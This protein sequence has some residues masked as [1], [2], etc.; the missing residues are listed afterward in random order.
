MAAALQARQQRLLVPVSCVGHQRCI[1]ARQR[2]QLQLGCAGMC[3]ILQL[4]SL[5]RSWMLAAWRRA[6]T[7]HPRADNWDAAA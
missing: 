5:E 2:A 6:Q 7:L 3:S 1:V 4:A